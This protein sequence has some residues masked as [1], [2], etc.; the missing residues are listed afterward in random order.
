MTATCK[1]CG[2]DMKLGKAIE[3][4]W[5]GTPDFPNGEVVTRSPG[6]PGK[7]IKVWKCPECGHSFSATGGEG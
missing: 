5:T 6:R 2:V 3:Q 7:L 4:T 1:R